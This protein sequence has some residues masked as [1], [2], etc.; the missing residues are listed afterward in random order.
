MEVDGAYS[1]KSVG[2]GNG[3]VFCPIGRPRIRGVGLVLRC[4]KGA[5][6]HGYVMGC[7]VACASCER[8]AAHGDLK[9]SCLIARPGILDE[10][11]LGP[12]MSFWDGKGVL[13]FVGSVFRQE[14]SR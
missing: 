7:I 8:S 13:D 6:G 4:V 9:V 2:L 1:E 11:P 5:S 12:A 14:S 3:K 10:G